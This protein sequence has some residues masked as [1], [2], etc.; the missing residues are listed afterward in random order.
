MGFL[1]DERERT[2]EAF[3][4]G[5]VGCCYAMVS[6]KKTL[7]SWKAHIDVGCRYGDLLL[8][9][10]EAK[11]GYVFGADPITDQAILNVQSSIKAVENFHKEN[12]AAGRIVPRL[13]DV[14]A[15]N[16]RFELL[17]IVELIERRKIVN[18]DFQIPGQDG[19]DVAA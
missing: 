19:A 1:E 10:D 17:A 2:L 8:L 4:S 13:C 16:K 14:L 12:A 5:I 15:P 18:Q 7:L 3:S 9:L 11:R 6:G